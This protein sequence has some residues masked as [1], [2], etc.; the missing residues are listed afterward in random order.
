MFPYHSPLPAWSLCSGLASLLNS[1][2]HILRFQPHCS[3][4]SLHISYL[5]RFLLSWFVPNTSLTLRLSWCPRIHEILLH[6][7][8]HWTSPHSTHFFSFQDFTCGHSPVSFTDTLEES[9]GQELELNLYF[10]LP[11]NLGKSGIYKKGS[12]NVCGVGRGKHWESE[13]LKSL[14][15]SKF[16]KRQSQYP[17]SCSPTHKP[18]IL[19]PYKAGLF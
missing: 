14:T 17:N 9:L 2:G 4:C 6:L 12:V 7:L 19:P 13:S 18:W 1:P 5:N 15:R 3:H 11:K 10:C 8:L 16:N